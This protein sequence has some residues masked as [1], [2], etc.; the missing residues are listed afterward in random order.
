MEMNDYLVIYDNSGP[1]WSAYVPDLPG[2]ITT[3][4]TVEEC[5]KNIQEA[6][7]LFIETSRQVGKPVPPPTTQGEYVYIPGTA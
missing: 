2:C 4:R 6:V 5:K 1:N 7:T 3:G